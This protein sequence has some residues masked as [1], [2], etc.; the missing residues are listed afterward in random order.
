MCRGAFFEEVVFFSRE[1]T[2]VLQQTTLTLTVLDLLPTT[3]STTALTFLSC[4]FLYYLL[5]P[6]SHNIYIHIWADSF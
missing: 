3:A 1:H 6:F 2:R 5:M 4:L